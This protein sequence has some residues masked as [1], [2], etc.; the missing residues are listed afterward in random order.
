[1]PGP[2][3][4]SLL[5]GKRSR[6]L[7]MLQTFDGITAKFVIFQ[8]IDCN[9][10]YSFSYGKFYPK[11]GFTIVGFNEAPIIWFNKKSFFHLIPLN[12]VTNCII[13]GYLALQGTSN[14]FKATS[15]ER[16]IKFTIKTQQLIY[17]GK[18][19]PTQPGTQ[20]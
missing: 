8:I 5:L 7:S 3:P 13:L 14:K 12:Y 18:G 11:E 6:K 16:N 19:Q 10:G 2:M 17:P 15:L 4:W 20:I 1:M 9:R